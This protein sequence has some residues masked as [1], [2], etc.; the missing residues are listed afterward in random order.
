MTKNA[1]CPEQHHKKP[2]QYV[3]TETIQPPDSGAFAKCSPRSRRFVS[4]D[5]TCD[6]SLFVCLLHFMKYLGASVKVDAISQSRFNFCRHFDESVGS[7]LTQA[8]NQKGAGV[9]GASPWKIFA[10]SGK[11]VCI[12]SKTIGH[13]FKNLSPLRKPFATLVSQA[14]YGP[15]LTTYEY[16]ACQWVRNVDN[17]KT[18]Q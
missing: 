8:R 13:K 1:L 5:N 18:C 7:S 4:S 14:G 2:V 17:H 3:A 10:P 11:M 15:G 9:G 12:Y 6:V 16:Q